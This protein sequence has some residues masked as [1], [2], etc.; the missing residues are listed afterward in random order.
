MTIQSDHINSSTTKV[1]KT[2]GFLRRNINISSTKVKEQAYKSLVRQSLE[3]AYFVWDLY[4]PTRTGTTESCYHYTS[5]VSNMIGHLNLRS[6]ADRRTAACLVMLYKISHELVT[7]PQKQTCSCHQLDA[8]GTYNL[9][10]IKYHPHAYNSD[11]NLSFREQY[12]TG[13][14]SPENCKEYDCWIIQISCF[15]H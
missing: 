15:S 10:H 11:S 14:V 3:Y 6:L 13:T 8:T 7:I 1:S 12:E 2:L 9:S 5:S 4:I